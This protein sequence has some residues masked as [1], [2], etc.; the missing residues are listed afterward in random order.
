MMTVPE[1]HTG[2]IGVMYV[3]GSLTYVGKPGTG[4]ETYTGATSRQLGEYRTAS[5]TQAS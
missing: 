3:I 5:M 4:Q 1:Y 2:T